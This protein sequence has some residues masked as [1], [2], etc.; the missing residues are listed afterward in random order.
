MT[1]LE[2]IQFVEKYSKEKYIFS[3]YDDHDLFRL[4]G[5]LTWMNPEAK[6]E[7]YGESVPFNWYYKLLDW[8]MDRNIFCKIIAWI[9]IFLFNPMCLILYF[10]FGILLLLMEFGSRP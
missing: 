2:M 7:F 4:C 6:E 3:N 5:R 8:L 1:R 10:V 9:L